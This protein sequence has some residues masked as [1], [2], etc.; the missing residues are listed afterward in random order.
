MKK[1]EAEKTGKELLD[2]VGLAGKYDYY[3]AQLSGGMQQRVGIARAMAANPEVIL[4]MSRRPH[5][6]RSWWERC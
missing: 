4:L 6:I 3:P 5:S 2:K 1:E